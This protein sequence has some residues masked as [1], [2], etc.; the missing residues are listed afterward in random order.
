MQSRARS[1]PQRLE[2]GPQ[3]TG[4]VLYPPSRLLLCHSF[5]LPEL[6][7]PWMF[8]VK[9]LASATR[10]IEALE[11]RK[12]VQNDSVL[13]PFSKPQQTSSGGQSLPER[14]WLS[15]FNTNILFQV[16]VFVCKH[17]S[18]GRGV[19]LGGDSILGWLPLKVVGWWWLELTHCLEIK[20]CRLKELQFCKEILNA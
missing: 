6:F 13:Q 15:T 16:E 20:F 17:T 5:R 2:S 3:A 4:S 14:R 11:Q 7:S 18:L 12:Q 10:S 1:G 9:L 8:K 19:E